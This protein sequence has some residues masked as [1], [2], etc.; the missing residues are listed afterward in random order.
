MLNY[1]TTAT[2]PKQT[3][4]T[5]KSFAVIEHPTVNDAM[6]KTFLG[7]PIYSLGGHV[8]VMQVVFSVPMFI[9]FTILNYHDGTLTLDWAL[10]SVFVAS[11]AGL[12]IAIALWYA[13]TMPLMKK[14]NRKP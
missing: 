12:F 7:Q 2:D 8:V 10:F 11:L 5:M 4:A 14:Y 13:V 6:K 3:V 1:R 9:I